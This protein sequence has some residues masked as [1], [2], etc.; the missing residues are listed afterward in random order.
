VTLKKDSELK[1]ELEAEENEEGDTSLSELHVK[2]KDIIIKEHLVE[3]KK[4]E[5]KD[6][7]GRRDTTAG[8]H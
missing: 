3:E 7:K 2:D 4:A 6:K 5:S 1:S 8:T